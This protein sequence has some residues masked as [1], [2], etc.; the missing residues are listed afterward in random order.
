MTLL[1]WMATLLSLV[2]AVINIRKN[3]WGFMLWNLAALCWIWIA[4][5]N[6]PVLSGLIATQILFISLNLYGFREW[7]RKPPP[8]VERDIYGG[9]C[10][11]FREP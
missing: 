10:S 11:S 3:R 5:L 9:G 6:S 4:I 7:S 1:Q 2:G 8:P